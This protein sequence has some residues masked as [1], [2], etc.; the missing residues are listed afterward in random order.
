[1]RQKLYAEFKGEKMTNLF[2]KIREMKVP[3]VPEETAEAPEVAEETPETPE[4]SVQCACGAC[5]EG[6]CPECNA[7]A[8]AE[9]VL[10]MTK[11]RTL[12]TGINRPAGQIPVD[13]TCPTCGKIFQHLSRH[14][15][16]VVAEVAAVAEVTTEEATV[17]K[18]C[19]KCSAP[20]V[21]RL[22]DGI[23][24]EV[25][26]HRDGVCITCAGTRRI[27]IAQPGIQEDGTYLTPLERKAITPAPPA[28][29]V[30]TPTAPPVVAGEYPG[31]KSPP[32]TKRFT[33]IFD[34]IV[35]KGECPVRFEDF[36][37][38]FCAAVEKE[39]QLEHWSLAEY[40][41]GPGLL[42]SRLDR[43]LKESATLLGPMCCDS[44][45]AEVRACKSVLKRYATGII[46][47]VR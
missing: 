25:A 9:E 27:R 7:P 22:A 17:V 6:D 35:E 13:G 26:P 10:I 30:A 11:L 43:F 23:E 36:I 4:G 38:P 12:A 47:G 41:K 15:C 24:T 18:A 32:S 28:P 20:L 34:A 44:Q 2:D 14:R 19:S 16:K 45:S 8:P 46:Q 3:V 31:K 5:L 39:N 29:V 33:L 42:A 21:L 40:G 37:V 1:V